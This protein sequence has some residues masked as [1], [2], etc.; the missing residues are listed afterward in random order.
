MDA[1]PNDNELGVLNEVDTY[2]YEAVAYLRN[3]DEVE[4]ALS[5]SRGTWVS[6]RTSPSYVTNTHTFVV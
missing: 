3:R 6:R 1:A 2:L 5:M 4:A